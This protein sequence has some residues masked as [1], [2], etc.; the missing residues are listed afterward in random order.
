M[1]IV[2]SLRHYDFPECT[3]MALEQLASL[4]NH[5]NTGIPG[6]GVANED[7]AEQV[8]GEFI[9]GLSSAKSRQQRVGY[10]FSFYY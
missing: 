4:L 10:C 2:Q 6:L 1:D 7:L 5:G 8:V 9:F 3:R